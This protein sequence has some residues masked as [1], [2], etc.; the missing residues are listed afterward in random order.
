MQLTLSKWSAV[1]AIA[2]AEAGGVIF[3]ELIETDGETVL[4]FEMTEDGAAILK[5]MH[6][7]ED[8]Y[9][10]DRRKVDLILALYR[11]LAGPGH[12]TRIELKVSS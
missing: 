4:N 8:M 5:R 3:T 7:L 11:E 2:A 12:E 10:D 1:A 9:G 6:S